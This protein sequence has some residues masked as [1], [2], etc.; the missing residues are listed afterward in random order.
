MFAT[1]VMISKTSSSSI[2]AIIS[3]NWLRFFKYA[4]GDLLGTFGTVFSVS[5]PTFAKKELKLL[6]IE[7]E[8]STIFPLMFS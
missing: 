1:E 8:S 2:W 4:V 3:S 5:G 7:L 6:A